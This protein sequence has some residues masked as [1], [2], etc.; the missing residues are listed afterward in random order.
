MAVVIAR[1]PPVVAA[2]A[3][4]LD[5]HEW[6]LYR[7]AASLDGAAQ[8]GAMASLRAVTV[9]RES[10]LREAAIAPDVVI[11]SLDLLATLAGRAKRGETSASGMTDRR[12]AAYLRWC[13]RR[14]RDDAEGDGLTDADR[15]AGW[16]WKDHGRVLHLYAPKQHPSIAIV[17]RAG[18]AHGPEGNA[19]EGNDGKE[20]GRAGQRAVCASLREAGALRSGT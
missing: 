15:K 13:V 9:T 2:L 7:R 4:A 19:T 18:W 17:N 6:R 1:I 16:T 12:A 11:G 3:A 14:L 8:R 20:T 10:L 5:A